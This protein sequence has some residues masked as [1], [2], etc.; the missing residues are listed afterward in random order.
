MRNVL[1]TIL[2]LL[3]LMTLGIAGSESRQAE[4]QH[5]TYM[6]MKQ[7]CPMRVSGTDLS[8]TDT[9][10][11][12]DLTLTTKS[13]DVAELRRRVENM[14]KMHSAPSNTAM[15]GNRIPFSIKYEEVVY[16]ARLT[17]TPRNPA[18]LDAFRA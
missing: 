9:E 2:A 7:S 15:H 5:Q 13:G 3:S 4:P 10:N 11:G 8:T 17:L 14:A 12:I 1:M 16:G 6:S 18:Q